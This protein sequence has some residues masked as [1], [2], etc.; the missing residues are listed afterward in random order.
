MKTKKA[1]KT[2]KFGLPADTDP[3]ELADKLKKGITIK[4]LSDLEELRKHD[5]RKGKAL[6]ANA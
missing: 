1:A 4:L 5:F 6:K 2:G 3:V